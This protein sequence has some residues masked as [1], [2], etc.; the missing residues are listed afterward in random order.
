MR[1]TA[2]LL[3]QCV[4][5]TMFSRKNCS[6]CDEGKEVLSKVWNKKPFEYSEVDVM[7]KK[8][9]KWKALYEFDVPVVSCDSIPNQYA[10]LNEHRFTLT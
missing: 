3:K 8:Q 9:E 2:F 7:A 1:S 4:R 6:L 5:V 10:Q